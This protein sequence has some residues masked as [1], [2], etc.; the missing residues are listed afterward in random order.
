MSDSKKIEK[1]ANPSVDD[2]FIAVGEFSNI[3][4]INI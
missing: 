3:I 1:K 2:I 4:F